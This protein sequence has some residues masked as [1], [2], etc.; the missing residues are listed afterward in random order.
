M[1]CTP[2]S[3]IAHIP[4][5][6]MRLLLAL[7]VLLVAL[8]VAAQPDQHAMHHPA[9][10][11]TVTGSDTV[12]VTPDRATIS[13]S[14]VTRAQEPEAAREQNATAA[15]RALDAIRELDVPERQI[16]LQNLRLDEDVEY[17]NGRR[18]RKG[19]IA[20]RDVQIIL[21]DL[22]LL[23]TVVARVVQEGANELNGITYGLQDPKAAEDEALSRAARRAQS[24]ARLLAQTLGVEIGLVLNIQEGSVSAPSP[25]PPVMY[26]RA[27]MAMADAAPEPGAFAEG[28]IEV[29]ATVTAVFPVLD[30]E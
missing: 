23:P 10:T 18:I 6:S 5:Y 21:D 7:L 1:R 26:A 19:F 27:E 25:R 12:S 13:F 30:L 28:E 16:Q 24:K 29:R 9:R 14:V 3:R 2:R 4:L 20:R 22:D 8:P 17:Q 11:V 15:R